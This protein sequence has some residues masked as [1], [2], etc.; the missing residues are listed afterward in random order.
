MEL[1]TLKPG[2]QPQIHATFLEAFADYAVPLQPSSEELRRMMV[3]RG[4]DH[5]L[6]VGAFDAGRLVAVMATGLGEWR[7]RATAYDVFTGVVPGH[8]GR[9]LAG[10]LLDHARPVL[11]RRGAERFL[12]EVLR[13]N[14]PAVRAY[15]RAG[16]VVTRELECLRVSTCERAPLRTGAT[17]DVRVVDH[18]DWQQLRAFHDWQPSWQNSLAS[19]RRAKGERVVLGAY[20]D[21]VL[22]GYAVLFVADGDVAQLAVD[23]THRRRGV[24]TRLLAAVLARCPADVAHIRILNVPRDAGADLAFYASQGAQP[25]ASQYEMVADL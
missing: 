18:P 3:R 8:R 19:V 20:V 11:A 13:E 25:L 22:T 1:R 17:V 6:S 12:L 5:A 24:A 7:G 2:D 9:G 21:G 23:P 15:R 16:F 4:A 10:A 14:E